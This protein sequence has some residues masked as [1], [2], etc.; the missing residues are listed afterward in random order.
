MSLR[1]GSPTRCWYD[2]QSVLDFQIRAN[3]LRLT[4]TGVYRSGG[5]SSFIYADFGTRS[6]R[7]VLTVTGLMQ[8]ASYGENHDPYMLSLD[9]FLISNVLNARAFPYSPRRLFPLTALLSII[10]T[11]LQR[12][13]IHQLDRS[14]PLCLPRYQY[15]PDVSHRHSIAALPTYHGPTT[16]TRSRDRV[17]DGRRDAHRVRSRLHHLCTLVL[18]PVCDAEFRLLHVCASH[19]RS[20]GESLHRLPPHTS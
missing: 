2:S 7:I 14:L 20:S 4:M 11:L 15:R 10:I 1:T 6:G 17:Y 16:R 5:V 8:L 9:S 18:D 13:S 12:R 3:T 19:R